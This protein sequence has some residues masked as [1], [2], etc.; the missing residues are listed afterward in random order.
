VD[1]FSFAVVMHELYTRMEPWPTLHTPSQITE[2]VQGGHR[3]PIPADCPLKDIITSSW[4]QDPSKRPS[5]KG[6]H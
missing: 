5:F 6:L 4:D 2:K 3:L 1:V